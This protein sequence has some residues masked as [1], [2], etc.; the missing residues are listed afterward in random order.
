MT[1]II[2]G[3]TGITNVNGSAAAPAETG[4]DTDTGIVYGTNTLSLATGGTTALTANSAQGI[5]V[6]NTLG[7]GNATPSAS[8]A[9]I[10]FPATQSASTNANTLDDY[11]EGTWTPAFSPTGGGSISISVSSARYTKIGQSV[12]I[13]AFISVTSVSSPSGRLGVVGLPFAATNN[14]CPGVFTPNAFNSF[15]GY[16]GMLVEAAA[17]ANLDRYDSTGIAA[18]LAGYVK[19]GSTIFLNATFFV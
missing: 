5:Q 8:G 7:V 9:G 15:V 3:T 12:T 4:T 18:D 19:A 6:L 16:T 13:T 14:P 1:V 2:N 11:E 17:T 10:T